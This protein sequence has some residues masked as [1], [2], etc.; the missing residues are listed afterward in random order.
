MWHGSCLGPG[1]R[2][3]L[4]CIIGL[5][6][7]VLAVGGCAST[8]PDRT[9][10]VSAHGGTLAGPLQ[11]RAEAALARLAPAVEGTGQVR[12]SVLNS[13]AM[14]AFSWPDGTVYVNRGLAEALDDRDL[15]AAIAH[16]LGHLLNDGHLA[17][18]ASL[19]GCC[20][21]PDGEARADATGAQILRRSGLDPGSMRSM[22]ATLRVLLPDA[23]LCRAAIGRR[24][25]LLASFD[26][27]H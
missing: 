11:A 22:L 13:P 9:A 12:I 10:W 14:G 25:D 4:S 20:T 26:L 15:T 19:R 1:V 6:W 18:V 24:V 8:S 3:A 23:P 7:I 27:N 16:E 17:G 2:R 21:S 5:S